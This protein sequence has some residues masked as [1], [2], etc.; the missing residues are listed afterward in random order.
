MM[1]TQPACKDGGNSTDEDIGVGLEWSIQLE[2]A[3]RPYF[4][5]LDQLMIYSV[6]HNQVYRFFMAF[7]SYRCSDCNQLETVFQTSGNPEHHKS[8][9]LP[10]AHLKRNLMMLKMSVTKCEYR[11]NEWQDKKKKR[12]K[13]GGLFFNLTRHCFSVLCL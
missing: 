3:Q 5:S 12:P 8:T 13:T 2:V 7:I 1:N 11:G 9:L 10:F 6:C 4:M